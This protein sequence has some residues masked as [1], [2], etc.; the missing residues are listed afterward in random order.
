MGTLAKRL[1]DFD[2]LVAELRN[3]R[4][5]FY[6]QEIQEPMGSNILINKEKYLC[7]ASYSYL[8]LLHHPKIDAAAKAAIDKHG[9][10]THG[11]RILA[12]TTSLHVELENKIAKK[13]GREAAIVYSSGYVTNLATISTLLSHEAAVYCDKL[14]H[15][16]IVD[17]CLLSGAK[18]RRFKHNDVTSLEAKLA[19]DPDIPDK[20]VIVDAVYS[21]DGDIA[22]LPE[23]IKVAKKYKAIVMV[24]EA[25]SFGV[26]GKNGVGIEDHYG[27]HGQVDILMGTLS[28]TIPAIG[29]YIA[30][31]HQI[32]DYLKH[33]ARAFVFSAALPPPAVGASIA[34]LD[35][36]D[37]EPWRHEQLQR[38]FNYFKAGL[39][40]I[41]YSTLNS[42]TPIVPIITYREQ[43]TLNMARRLHDDKIFVVPIL[44]PA[45]PPN[46]CRLRANVTADHTNEDIDRALDSLHKAGREEGII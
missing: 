17:G 22:P 19:A 11:V 41:G 7:F 4:R 42:E 31:S 34:A 5:Y 30:A 27:I 12:G 14:D 26:L 44:P 20:L 32:I 46:T 6:L 37:E 36:I 33:N 1:A 21:M 43:P 18:F 24:D 2:S 15:A 45:V 16:S 29:G 39:N 3:T 8:G 28:K 25:H 38:N 35:V 9:S 40:A 23:I 13:K 10:G